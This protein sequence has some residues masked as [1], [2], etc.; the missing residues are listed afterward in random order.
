MGC[1]ALANPRKPDENS[2]GVRKG[3]DLVIA[4]DLSNS[5][6]AIDVT[7]TRL[8]KAKQFLFKLIENMPEDRMGL[9]FFAGNAYEQMPLTFDRQ[10]ANMYIT[11]ADPRQINMQ[12][13]SIG[14]ALTKANFMLQGQAQRFRS[15]LL[16]TD[17]ETHD[18]NALETAQQLAKAGIMVNTVGIGSAEGATV[19]DSLGHPKTDA[20]GQVVISKLNE[21]LLKQLASSTNGKY[22]HLENTDQGVKEVLAQ[23][24]QIDK[25]ALGDRAQFTYETFY[26]WLALPMLLLLLAE[27]FLPD[28]KLKKI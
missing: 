17:G 12:G 20:T 3:I 9:I 8:L 18:D 11:A 27:I 21:Q 25:K 28:S 13:T 14:E 6:M 26:W 10:V 5:M 24:S 23:F 7:P 4:L 1:L 19:S 15:A 16:V 22:I 2:V